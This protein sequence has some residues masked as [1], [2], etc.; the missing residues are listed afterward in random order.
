[1]NSANAISA[2]PATPAPPA[3]SGRRSLATSE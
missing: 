3:I 2:Q 1:V